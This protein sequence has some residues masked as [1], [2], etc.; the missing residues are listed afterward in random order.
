M[1]SV[2]KWK[3]A[4]SCHREWTLRGLNKAPNKC[5]IH[6]MWCYF[7]ARRLSC[8]PQT[9]HVQHMDKRKVNFEMKLAIG[10]QALGT[11]DGRPNDTHGG[12][13]R[14]C[15]RHHVM[16]SCYSRKEQLHLSAIKLQNTWRKV[17]RNFTGYIIHNALLCACNFRAV[18]NQGDNILIIAVSPSPSLPLYSSL[19]NK[20]AVM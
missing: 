11:G 8:H 14:Y 17:H 20:A 18:F 10:E 1:Q 13:P 5:D 6:H 19:Q 16:Q 2:T 9:V 15:H 4:V 12:F 3:E 7:W